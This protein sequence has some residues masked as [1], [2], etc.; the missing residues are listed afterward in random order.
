MSKD[1]MNLIVMNVAKTLD[2][3]IP[4]FLQGRHSKE[5]D[6]TCPQKVKGGCTFFLPCIKCNST[7]TSFMPFLVII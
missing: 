6:L 3:E 7:Q 1:A 4:T 2:E 5:R